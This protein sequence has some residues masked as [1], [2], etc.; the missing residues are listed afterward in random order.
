MGY[1][2]IHALR[3]GES[4]KMVAFKQDRLVLAPFPA[5]DAPARVFQQ[6]DLLEMNDIL[7]S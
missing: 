6:K 3:Q 7:C 1:R 2:A 5:K 4:H